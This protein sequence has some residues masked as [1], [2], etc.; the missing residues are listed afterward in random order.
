M[1]V[2]VAKGSISSSEVSA[3]STNACAKTACKEIAS[4]L[5][6]LIDD[7]GTPQEIS[8]SARPRRNCQPLEHYG[9]PII[10]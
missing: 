1:Y 10:Y 8:S 5:T 4:P 7:H 9:A 2:N 6:Q 3:G